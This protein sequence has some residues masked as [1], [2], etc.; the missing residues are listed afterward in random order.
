MEK[1]NSLKVGGK[2]KVVKIS[3]DDSLRRRL[4]DMGLTPGA[5]VEV[6]KVAPLGDPMEIKVRGYHLSLRK[7][8]ASGVS[9]EVDND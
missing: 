9:V 5:R 2:G 6:I 7:E 1:M 8:E 3:G 4:L